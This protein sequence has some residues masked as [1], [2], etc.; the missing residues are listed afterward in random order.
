MNTNTTLKIRGS[1][2]KREP[3]T[4]FTGAITD[5]TVIAEANQP[6]HNYYGR[7][8]DKPQP[9]SLFLFTE[10]YYTLEEAL[11]FTQNIDICSRNMVNVASAVIQFSGEQYPAI[12]IRNFP[13]YQR[14]GILQECYSRQGMKFARKVNLEKEGLMRVD[15]CFHVED[16]GDGFYMDID[17]P[18]EGYF[19]MPS[20][21]EI[22][23]F[24]QLLRN[25]RNNSQC[26]FFD[27]AFGGFIINGKVID[28][29]RVYSGH[30]DMDLLHCVRNGT[31]RWMGSKNE[32]QTFP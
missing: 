24:E 27:A 3:L 28:I 1:I 19:Q 14:I 29:M 32:L 16:V 25:I 26:P 11:R 30:L 9:N 20:Y 13:D 18:N 31:L 21:P 12:R 15:K 10:R 7:I 8:P 6:Y 2:M 5:N 23:E 17:M 4:R 22:E